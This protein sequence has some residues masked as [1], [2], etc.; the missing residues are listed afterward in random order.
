MAWDDMDA[1]MA[2]MAKITQQ[3]GPEKLKAVELWESIP[4]YNEAQVVALAKLAQKI[5]FGCTDEE[6]PAL[7]EEFARL[8]DQVELRE[9]PPEKIYLWPEGVLPAETEYTDN[10]NYRY[11]HDPDFIPYMFEM[12]VPED[13]TPKGAIVVCAGGDHGDAVLHEGYQTSKDLNALGYQ[14]FLLLN[15][16]NHSPWNGH[17]CGADGARAIRY[18]RAHAE[19]YRIRPD[20]IA[21][22]GFS[23]GGLTGEAVIENYSGEQKVTDYFPD[24]VPDELDNYY[25]APDAF[26]CIYGPRFDG[27]PFNWDGVVFPPTFFAVGRED[28]AMNNLHY[29][30]PDLLA[31]GVPVEVHTFAGVPHGKAGASIYGDDYPSFDLWLTLADYFL[32]DIFGKEQ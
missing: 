26:L 24:Y 9:D 15:R 3:F 11:N 13:V 4:R 6:R 30:Y 32:Q 22:A 7:I 5:Q 31:H 14:C 23:N 25:G 21:F 29:M 16:T 28:S 27:A 10:S 20:S 12:L 8:R 18:V 19:K 1:F 17:E 2:R